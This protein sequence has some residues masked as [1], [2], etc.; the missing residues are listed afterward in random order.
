MAISFLAPW[1]YVMYGRCRNVVADLKVGHYTGRDERTHAVQS[2]QRV[3]HLPEHPQEIR[4][5]DRM[6]GRLLD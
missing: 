4:E 3:G 6:L 1:T 5:D 2:T